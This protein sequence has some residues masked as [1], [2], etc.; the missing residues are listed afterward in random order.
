MADTMGTPTHQDFTRQDGAPGDP[1]P[2]MFAQTPIYARSTGKRRKARTPAA[3]PV[4][5]APVAASTEPR[6]FAAPGSTHPAA[7]GEPAADT[8]TGTGLGTVGARRAEADRGR[9]KGAPMGAIAAGAVALVAVAG[10]ASYALNADDEPATAVATG[11]ALAPMAA[12]TPPSPGPMAAAGRAMPMTPA[13]AA[14]AE[15]ATPAIASPL[16]QARERVRTT[17]IARTATR[18]AASSAESEAIDASGTVALPAGPQ[19]Y[20]SI[21]SSPAA[22]PPALVIPP[23]PPAAEAPPVSTPAAPQ[24]TGADAEPTADTSVTP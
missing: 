2:S 12:A 15:P 18:P 24:A 7:V 16:P 17:G 9:S 5:A 3:R 1:E 19:P 6:S 22:A 4:A 11:A 21:A 13:A 20:T 23:A 14:V 10:V 8:A